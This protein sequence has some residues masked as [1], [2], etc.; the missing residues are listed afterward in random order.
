MQL[1]L[2]ERRAMK[3]KLTWRIALDL[4]VPAL[5]IM[6]AVMLFE[7]L[8]NDNA[9]SYLPIIIFMIVFFISVAYFVKT[10]KTLYEM[11]SKMLG[12]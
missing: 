3:H 8:F 9:T 1:L 2:R 7:S 5:A 10:G 11:I 6:A 12:S 4:I